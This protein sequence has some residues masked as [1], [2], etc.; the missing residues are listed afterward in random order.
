MSQAGEFW[1]KLAFEATPALPQPPIELSAPLG[2]CAS[3]MLS[4]ANPT[5]ADAIFTTTSSCPNR[6]WLSPD[7]VRVSP[8]RFAV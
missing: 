8:S 4:I 6:F 2:G 3:Y 7:S 5:A 1:W